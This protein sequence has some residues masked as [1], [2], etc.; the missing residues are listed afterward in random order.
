M[1]ILFIST[2]N[3]NGWFWNLKIVHSCN[4]SMESAPG[5]NVHFKLH[6][7]VRQLGILH[8]FGFS[9]ISQSSKILCTLLWFIKYKFCKCTN[10]QFIKKIIWK[11]VKNEMKID[12]TWILSRFSKYS[13][14]LGL[15]LVI[16]VHLSF[17]CPKIILIKELVTFHEGG[18]QNNCN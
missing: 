12:N 7:M 9:W 4:C 6:F 5:R 3:W 1:F 18:C 8:D 15:W 10:V 11:S 2:E 17:L 13:D 14:A 16:F